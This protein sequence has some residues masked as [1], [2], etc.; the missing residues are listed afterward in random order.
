MTFDHAIKI[1]IYPNKE[2]E[3]FFSKNF[4][5][6]RFVY[7][8]MLEERKEF[9]RLYEHDKDKSRDHE[10]RTEKQYKEIYTFLK[11]ADSNSLQQ[12][13]RNL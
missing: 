10:Y 13:R 3:A 2:H 11:E 8:K 5:C 9:Y 1:R 6:C 12:A 4:G 7:N